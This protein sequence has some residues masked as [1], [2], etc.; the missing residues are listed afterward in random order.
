MTEEKLC[1]LWEFVNLYQQMDNAAQTIESRKAAL[2]D[3][4][5]AMYKLRW[6]RRNNIVVQTV[7]SFIDYLETD[8]K[9]LKERILYLCDWSFCKGIAEEIPI[10]HRYDAALT[11]IAEEYATGNHD[12][13]TS[14]V[15]VWEKVLESPN[16]DANTIKTITDSKVSAQLREDVLIPLRQEKGDSDI[17]EYRFV[18]ENETVKEF[19][20]NKIS[21]KKLLTQDR[22]LTRE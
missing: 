12:T 11:F 8:I 13:V 19:A 4:K 21:I 9:E 6:F 1:S 2:R 10:Q 18:S 22:R 3:A 20:E 16:I 15:K 17:E 7:L 5:E 14:A